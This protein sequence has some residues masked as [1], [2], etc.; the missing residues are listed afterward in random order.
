[1][2]AT[3]SFEAV[4]SAGGGHRVIPASISSHDD[5]VHHGNL[6]GSCHSHDVTGRLEI[7]VAG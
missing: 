6:Y 1:M 5:V 7:L 4:K 2:A 3:A